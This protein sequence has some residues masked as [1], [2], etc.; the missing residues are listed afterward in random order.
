MGHPPFSAFWLALPALAV[1]FHLFR[2]ARSA[3]A[4][5]LTLWLAGLGY[6]ALSLAWLV[7]PFF[8]DP[9]RHGWMAPFA[10]FLMAG[11]LALFWAGSA[12]LAFRLGASRSARAAAL[13]LILTLAEYARSFV[14][15]GFPWATIGHV[16]IGWPMMQLAAWGGAALLTL[17]ALAVSALL[18]GA[19]PARA[20]AVKGGAA[21]ALLLA[22]AAF[23]LMR[24]AG[25]IPSARLGIIRLGQ[26]AIPQ[27]LKW[28][29]DEAEAN[30]QRLFA[31]AAAAPGPLGAPDLTIFPETAFPYFLDGAEPLLAELRQASGG[32]LWIGAPRSS[33][34][35]EG[36]SV[37]NSLAEIGADGSAAQ[38]YDKHHLVPFGEYVPFGP[39]LGALGLRAMV[40]QGSFT[41]GP[42]PS[43]LEAGPLG[44]ALPLICYEAI[45]PADILAAPERPD[46]LLQVTNDAWFGTL[47]GPYQHLAQARLRAVETGLPLLRAA[48]TGVSAAIDPLGR[49]TAS[50]GL[51]LRGTLDVPLTP[52]LPPTPYWLYGDLPLVSLL[53]LSLI[54]LSIRRRRVK[55]D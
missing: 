55:V 43:L 26:P 52:P 36:T 24:E 13:V 38:I 50:L 25:P 51:G 34:S 46:W 20:R 33:Q 27:S 28:D 39:L 4:A 19:V 16:F 11:G 40:E 15:T 35:A 12:A 42:G 7:N 32:G 54:G 14:F 6:F 22:A 10:L 21:L 45:F 18:A 3:R 29:A 9:W 49:V 31:L 1:V 48:N 44:K 47:Q 53:L 23:G 2:Q 30:Y 37:S 41:P 5:A 17:I 8:V